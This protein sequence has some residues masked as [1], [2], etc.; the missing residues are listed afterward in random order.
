MASATV[1]PVTVALDGPARAVTVRPAQTPAWGAEECCVVAV[2]TVCVV[3]VS[4]HS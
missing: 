2:A 3:S 1:G 4:A